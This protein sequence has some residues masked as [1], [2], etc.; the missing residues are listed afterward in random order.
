MAKKEKN[1]WIG[2]LVGP[3][4]VL[5]AL[6]ALWKNEVRFDYYRAASKT[7]PIVGLENQASNQL[8]SYTGPMDQSLTLTGDYVKNFTGYLTVERQAEIYC[9]DK[10]KD[11]DGDVTWSKKWQSKVE[12]NSRNSGIRRRLHSKN[13]L[14]KSYQV[15]DLPVVPQQIDF[16]DSKVTIELSQLELVGTGVAS[17]LK[18][19]GAYFYRS[20]GQS[21]KLGDERV[22]YK[23][24]PV[25]PTATYF[26]KLR[27]KTGV[28][29]DDQKRDGFIAN[30]LH[31]TGVLHYLV[32]GNRETALGTMKSHI[33]RLKWIVRGCGTTAVVAGFLFLFGSM[34]R[35]LY[36]IP[37]IGWLAEKGVIIL[38]LL[39]GIP[40][41]ILTILI[42][43]L[44]GNPVML[45]GLVAIVIGVLFYLASAR[46]KAK[47]TQ[48]AVRMGLNQKH[49]RELDLKDIKTLEFIELVHLAQRDSKI[50]STERDF[51]YRWGKKNG[52]KKDKCDQMIQQAAE[53]RKAP[54]FN[55]SSDSHLKNLIELA[56]AD[57]VVSP[58]EM[59]AIRHT[60][61]KVGYDRSTTDN[62]LQVVQK[63]ALDHHQ[64]T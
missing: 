3:A 1:P 55:E 46:S 24:I 40:L 58:Y 22:S 25:P 13:F 61:T 51:L 52:W 56:L 4:M 37:V 32:A 59:R 48:Q 41:A 62:L 20:N 42:A 57:G 21:T 36:Q 16:V 12:N 28:P 34:V 50:E 38:S 31:D 9:W 26:G 29:Y 35:F 19:R 14:P 63:S 6:T 45:L 60:A 30:L 17:E 43:Y 18:K 54:E 53:A 27:E 44:V 2:F 33:R 39:L 47:A 23:A 11:S 15:G 5:A 64:A 7:T 49:G 10:H 8:I